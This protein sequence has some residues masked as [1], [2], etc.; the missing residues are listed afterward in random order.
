[1]E[2]VP[3]KK[4]TFEAPKS[5]IHPPPLQFDRDLLVSDLERHQVNGDQ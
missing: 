2:D 1:M 5:T 4:N 3:N